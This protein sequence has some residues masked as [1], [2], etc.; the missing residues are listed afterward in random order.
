L[1]SILVA[2]SALRQKSRSED[3]VH[4]P[5]VHVQKETSHV[6]FANKVVE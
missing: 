4:L 6:L 2:V 5:K 1:D 3:V